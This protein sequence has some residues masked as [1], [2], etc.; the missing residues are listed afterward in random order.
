MIARRFRSPLLG[1]VLVLAALAG[2]AV[3]L[4][5]LTA[6]GGDAISRATAEMETESGHIRA[7][8]R[9]RVLDTVKDWEI[10]TSQGKLLHRA[11]LLEPGEVEEDV[12][13]LLE[14]DQLELL[15]SAQTGDKDTAVFITLLPDGHEERTA[16][17]I[18][19]GSL[20]E[21]LHFHWEH[22]HE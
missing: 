15:V 11:D 7:V 18:G 13:I 3:P 19:T 20:E 8:L 1:T 16:Y 4:H 9:V 6:R 22:Q 2:L 5:R 17:A 21:T 10:R 14:N 12:D